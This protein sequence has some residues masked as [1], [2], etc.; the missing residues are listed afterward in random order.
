MTLLWEKYSFCPSIDILS[1]TEAVLFPTHLRYFP[2]IFLFV[3]R[4]RVYLGRGWGLISPL[5]FLINEPLNKRADFK[6]VQKLNHA[7]FIQKTF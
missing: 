2:L 4:N 1:C 5:E 6:I 3:D 7:T